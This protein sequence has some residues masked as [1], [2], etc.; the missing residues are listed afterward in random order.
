MTDWK[1]I[2]SSRSGSGDTLEDLLALNGFDSGAGN[3]SADD[4]RDYVSSV[5]EECG[6]EPGQSVIELGCGAG[7]FLLAL[8][9][10][11]GGGLEVSGVDY[12]PAL[13]SAARR[14]IPNGCF[15]EA[16]LHDFEIDGDFDGVLVHSVLHYLDINAVENLFKEAT[17]RARNFVALLDIPDS[18]TMRESERFRRGA[19]GQLEYERKYGNLRHTYF[20]LAFFESL[21]SSNWSM[22]RMMAKKENYG[23][24]H[25]RFSVVY[26]KKVGSDARL[27]ETVT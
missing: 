1:S 12:S 23:N 14:A 20:D 9:E 24:N 8:E 2:W 27:G 26:R 15:Q 17:K 10:A 3:V 5:A 25:Y 6:I 11:V 21:Q 13:L 4:W 7:A 22:E 19:L 18:K 16:D